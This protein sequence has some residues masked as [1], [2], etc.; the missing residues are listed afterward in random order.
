MWQ[1]NFIFAKYLSVKTFL[2]EREKNF[3]VGFSMSG[4]LIALLRCLAISGLNGNAT[5]VSN[6]CRPT[7]AI[8]RKVRGSTPSTGWAAVGLRP[9][10]LLSC[11]IWATE[12]FCRQLA[13]SKLQELSRTLRRL[14]LL[15]VLPNLHLNDTL[16]MRGS[17]L[18][19]HFSHICLI[20]LSEN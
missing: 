2:W 13:R 8:W 4:Y 10:L 15:L 14:F 20:Y 18:T 6:L 16:M 5:I 12:S 9:P 19:C 3:K 17:H 7:A 11:Q 1:C